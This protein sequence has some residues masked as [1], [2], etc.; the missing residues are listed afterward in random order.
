MVS[1]LKEHTSKITSL[2]LMYDDVH[3]VT[4]SRDKSM[5]TWDLKSDKR[6]A[7]QTQRIGGINTLDVT[8]D[9]NIVL[10]AGQEKKIN[11]WD[12]RQTQPIASIDAG[13]PP[14]SDEI[15]ALAVSHDG[16]YFATGGT[17]EVIRIWDVQSMALVAEGH[18][19]SNTISCIA[20]AYDN[21]QIISTGKDNCT[22]IWNV[23]L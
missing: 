16:R 8:R 18:G 17:K 15:T 7:S 22:M 11:K 12:L 9:A 1:H 2:Q 14:E 19:H 6:I 20:W 4:V 23:F 13:P 21:K 3:L 5:L 10:T